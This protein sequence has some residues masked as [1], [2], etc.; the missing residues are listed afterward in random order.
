MIKIVEA[1]TPIQLNQVRK[2]FLEYET[3]LGLD[4]S[5]QN[6]EKELSTLPGQYRLPEG[7]ILIAKENKNTAG[8][9]A[10]KLLEDKICEMKRFFVLPPARCAGLLSLLISFL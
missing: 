10:L 1:K 4:L 6:F 8:C 3:W 7:I 2:L 5:F 9:I